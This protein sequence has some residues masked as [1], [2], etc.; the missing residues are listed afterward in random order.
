MICRHRLFPL[1]SLLMK[2]CELASHSVHYDVAASSHAGSVCSLESFLDDL[3]AFIITQV[4]A[5]VCI[6]SCNKRSQTFI[7]FFL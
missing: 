2:K 6:H 5:I 7:F 1:L 4:N 3:R